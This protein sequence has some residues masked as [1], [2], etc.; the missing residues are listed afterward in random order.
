[1]SFRLRVSILKEGIQKYV[2]GAKGAS[3]SQQL[4]LRVTGILQETAQHFPLEAAMP[5]RRKLS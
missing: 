2:Y 1:M 3:T 5:N 4:S